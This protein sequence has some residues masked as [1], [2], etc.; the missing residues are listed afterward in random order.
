MKLQISTDLYRIVQIYTE[1][2][3]FLK[4]KI[5]RNL[6]SDTITWSVFFISGNFSFSSVDP[7][8]PKKNFGKRVGGS[9]QGMKDI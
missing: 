5:L 7:P 3:R 1:I 9:G 6:A 4:M 8:L 2:Y